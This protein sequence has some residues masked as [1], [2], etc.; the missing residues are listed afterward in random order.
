MAMPS[1]VSPSWIAYVVGVA[2]GSGVG[3][4]YGVGLFCTAVAVAV[5]SSIT[6]TGNSRVGDGV[7]V[8]A[9]VVVAVAGDWQL[10]KRPIAKNKNRT[11]I[12][13]PQRGEESS[14]AIAYFLKNSI[15]RRLFAALLSPSPNHPPPP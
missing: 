7:A 13:N 14:S 12:P 6:V 5:A 15:L 3:D 8:G 9:G 1:N 10:V 2:V 11:V 4:G